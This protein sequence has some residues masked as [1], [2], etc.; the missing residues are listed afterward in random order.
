MTKKRRIPFFSRPRNTPKRD[1]Y[2]RS[3]RRLCFDEFDSGKNWVK[4]A[5]EHGIKATT[6][7]RYYQTW[8][9]LPKEF[10]DLYKDALNLLRQNPLKMVRG[11]SIKLGLSPEEVEQILLRPWGLRSLLLACYGIKKID[12]RTSE[13]EQAALISME[14]AI[15]KSGKTIEQVIREN[16]AAAAMHDRVHKK[17]WGIMEPKAEDEGEKE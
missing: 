5:K 4:V 12:V 2:G 15:R 16:E 1:E 8:K 17:V 7:R 3:Q 10:E 14:R 6:C 13:S 9:K 11:L